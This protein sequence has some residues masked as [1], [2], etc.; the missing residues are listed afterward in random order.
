MSFI[1]SLVNE[2]PNVR[3]GFD[4][5]SSGNE[6]E[7]DI[8]KWKMISS[9]LTDLFKKNGKVDEGVYRDIEEQVLRT[10]SFLFNPDSFMSLF[11]FSM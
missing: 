3:M 2:I 6:Y 1:K 4:W 11:I 5:K 9:L 8:R 7:E 10:V